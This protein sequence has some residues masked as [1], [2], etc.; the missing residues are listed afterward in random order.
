MKVFFVF[1]AFTALSLFSS[2]LSAQPAKFDKPASKN[3]Y[4]DVHHLGAGKVTAKDVAAAHQKDL[5]TQQKYGVN[6]I[7]YW[8][9]EA[10]GDVYCLSS[11]ADTQSIRKTHA[12]A[13]GLLPA[14][15]YQVTP[16]QE[17]SIKGKNDFYLDLHQL[18]AGKVTA[19]DVAEAHQK[20][21]AIQKKYGVNLINYWLDEETGTIMCLA[22]APDS[23]AL[24][25]THKEAHGLVPDKVIK[26]KQGQ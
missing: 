25:N 21:L 7:K 8:I 17:E 5:E 19:K 9:D 16:G 1:T 12:E 11:S 2:Q 6:F 18:G 24:I 4:I 14:K 22:Q 13:H 26:V 15:F 10:N 3:L 20:D 23:T